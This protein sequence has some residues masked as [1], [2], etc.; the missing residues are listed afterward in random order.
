M[1]FDN[2]NQNYNQVKPN[3]ET[4]NNF[5]RNYLSYTSEKPKIPSSYYSPLNVNQIKENFFPIKK[6][7]LQS[8]D[9]NITNNNRY[10]NI[11]N[12][13]KKP[14]NNSL[15]V[16]DIN[17]VKSYKLS[18]RCV[19]PLDPKY[20]Y[21]MQMVE[22]N[23]DRKNSKID[24]SEI[25]N[26]H[27]QT[28]SKYD[29]S[30]TCKNLSTCDIYGAQPG[31]KSNISKFEERIHKQFFS[32]NNK[33]DIIGSHPGSLLR[34]IKTNR[35]T[36]PLMPDYPEIKGEAVEFGN[37]KYTKI[38]Y[39]YG[40]LLKYYNEHSKITNPY[41]DEK[42]KKKEKKKDN[43]NINKS[44]DINNN[45]VKRRKKSLFLDFGGDKKIYPREKYVNNYYQNNYYKEILD[46][47]L[48]EDDGNYMN[49][50]EY[51][52]FLFKDNYYQ[53]RN[54]FYDKNGADMRRRSID[55]NNKVMN[56]EY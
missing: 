6:N 13:P 26:N 29:N 24:Y 18:S 21:D 27:P 39:D 22:I 35:C 17:H 30:L 53:D 56:F 2:Y 14:R 33:G 12:N 37:E 50:R 4:P 47:I 7:F 8:L 55:N 5:N 36:N 20:N 52:D 16:S 42:F 34:G 46:N 28:Y 44:Q 3:P 19:N 49:N 41:L 9:Q 54:N 15:N 38:K 32:N 1:N 23:E 51:S 11:N 45:N 25:P 40:S 10:N 48:K 43:N 31:T